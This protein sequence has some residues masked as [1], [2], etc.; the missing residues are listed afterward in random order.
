[1]IRKKELTENAIFSV[2]VAEYGYV[3]CQLRDDCRMDIFDNLREHDDWAGEDLNEAN[4]LCTIVIAEHRLIK[5]FSQNVT[6]IVKPN[7]RPRTLI[8][9]SLSEDIRPPGNLPGFRL[10][11]Y[12]IRYD[13]SQVDVLIPMLSPEQHRDLI[14]SY[15]YIGMHG[16]VN[17]IR[18]R[19]I[20]YY[21]DGID[22]DKQKSVLYPELP[23]PPKG[24]KKISYETF[25]RDYSSL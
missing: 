20:R 7:Q 4:L 11:K 1:M 22:W 15:D 13:P 12:G 10:I 8:G 5:L 25:M 21:R 16:S 2:A 3:L 18:D 24:Y 19:I 17:E 6:P 14:Y 9:L 23:L